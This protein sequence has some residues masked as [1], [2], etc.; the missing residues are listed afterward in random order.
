MGFFSGF[1][2]LASHRVPGVVTVQGVTRSCSHLPQAVAAF[3]GCPSLTCSLCLWL[4]LAVC[5]PSRAWHLWLVQ[6]PAQCLAPVPP[7]GPA[8]KQL[9]LR[10]VC[11]VQLVVLSSLQ[12]PK[13]LILYRA[14]RSGPSK[15]FLTW[16][17]SL[18]GLRPI[19][20]TAVTLA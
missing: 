14:F 7:E 13:D 11:L 3:P 5:L 2:A 9:E 19:G 20:I 10:R 18:C 8:V 15:V 1:S 6:V 16:G 12:G 4:V 17:F